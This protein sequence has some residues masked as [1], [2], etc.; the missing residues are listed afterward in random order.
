VGLPRIY[1]GGHY[2]IDVMGGVILGLGGYASARYLLEAW[3]VP[4]LERVFTGGMWLRLLGEAV[5][6][7]WILQVATEFQD[8]IWI[9]DC[10]R[11]LLSS[12]PVTGL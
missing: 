6:F 5:V 1:V 2:P 10:L 7:T 9:R 12:H 3:L 11:F 4:R 8:V